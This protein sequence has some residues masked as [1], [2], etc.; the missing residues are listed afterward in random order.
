MNAPLT[1]VAFPRG[2]T[3]PYDAEE[4]ADDDTQYVGN[5]G[6]EEFDDMFPNVID[7][8]EVA[9]QSIFT[10]QLSAALQNNHYE[11]HFCIGGVD[12]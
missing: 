10:H 1:A 9:E 4:T 2:L 11:K 8:I 6:L 7:P 12:Q 5:T 3:R